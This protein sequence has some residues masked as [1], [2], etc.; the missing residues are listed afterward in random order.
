MDSFLTKSAHRKGVALHGRESNWALAHLRL[1]L[2]NILLDAKLRDILWETGM[3]QFLVWRYW[4]RRQ[5]VQSV[6]KYSAFR[7]DFKQLFFHVSKIQIRIETAIRFDLLHQFITSSWN[8][9]DR[10]SILLRDM[11][12]GI[13]RTL[14]T[15]FLFDNVNE[16]DWV[17]A[18]V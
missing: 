5:F 1:V 12:S 7:V 16:S 2:W 10:F 3:R 15:Y 18:F 11:A 4:G 6:L 13:S 14:R 8:L 17:W 9:R